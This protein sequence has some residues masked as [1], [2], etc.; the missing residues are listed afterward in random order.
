MRKEERV[1][2]DLP[3]DSYSGFK[4]GLGQSQESG[5]PSWFSIVSSE[6]QELETSTAAFPGALAGSWSESGPDRI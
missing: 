6:A 1:R 2:R 3:S 5:T 4:A